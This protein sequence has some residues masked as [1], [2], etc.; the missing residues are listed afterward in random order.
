MIYLSLISICL[1]HIRPD[2]QRIFVDVGLGFHVE[3]T[4]TEA[5]NFIALREEKIA[6]YAISLW[7]I[8]AFSYLLLNNI[9]IATKIF[10]PLLTKHRK[11]CQ[12]TCYG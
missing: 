6:R 9:F 12:C 5:L 8:K 2:A 4:W 10:M 11:I 7:L 3:F 1:L